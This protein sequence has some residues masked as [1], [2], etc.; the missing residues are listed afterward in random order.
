MKGD[1]DLPTLE[2]EKTPP[3]LPRKTVESERCHFQ[4]PFKAWN[5]NSGAARTKN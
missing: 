2:V 1:T 5:Q 3:R 4:D